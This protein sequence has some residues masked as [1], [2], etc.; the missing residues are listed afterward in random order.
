MRN[1]L[2]ISFIIVLMLFAACD[3][4]G[5]K[6]LG[7]AEPHKVEKKAPKAPAKAAGKTTKPFVGKKAEAAIKTGDIEGIAGVQIN[8]NFD[9]SKLKYV[10]MVPGKAAGGFTCMANAVMAGTIKAGCMGTKNIDGPGEIAVFK[11]ETLAEEVPAASITDLECQFVGGQG[12][13]I[14]TDK[15]CTVELEVMD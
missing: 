8:F 11:F 1:V 5:E 2:F 9:T 4:G 15:A 10:D 14:K 13:V 6:S 3:K 12:R 7:T